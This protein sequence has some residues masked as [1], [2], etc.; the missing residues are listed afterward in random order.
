M[1]KQNNAILYGVLAIFLTVG[2]LIVTWK[3]IMVNYATNKALSSQLDQEINAARAKKDSLDQTKIDL[4]SMQSYF[5]QISVSIA[6][7]S[8]EP[9]IISELEAIALKNSLVIPSISISGVNEVSAASAAEEAGTTA[10]S[11]G[12]TVSVSVSVTGKFEQLMSFIGSLEKSV[13]FMN[14]KALSF[15]E[16]EDGLLTLS[17][18]IEAYTRYVPTAATALAY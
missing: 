9:N 17:C 18:E 12:S 13:K 2:V 15:T 7:D 10:I 16:D 1:N 3:L 4:E 6:K 8:D 5:N 14:I 11:A